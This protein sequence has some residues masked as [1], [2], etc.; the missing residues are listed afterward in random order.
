M[1]NENLLASIS[2]FAEL[3]NNKKDVRVV[4]NEFVKSVFSLERVF[5]ADSNKIK[6]LLVEH[7]GFDIPE[8]VIKSSLNSLKNQGMFSKH[9]G[10][11]Q[12]I[13]T[14]ENG[15][16]IRI[17]VDEKL[18]EQT[19]IE[20][21][22]LEYIIHEKKIEISDKDK[23][24]IFSCFTSYLLDT[25]ITDD[26]S[27]IISQ[28]VI[29][30]SSEIDFITALDNIREG[31]ILYQ[32]IV[33]SSDLNELD[34]WSKELVIYLDTELLFNS[35]GVNGEL[36][37]KLFD[38]FYEL[39]KDINLK[40]G[41]TKKLIH[42]KYF[43]EVEQEIQNYFYVAEKILLKEATLDPSKP[44]M[45]KILEGCSTISDILR[46]KADFF[47]NLKSR[48]ILEFSMEFNPIDN[49]QFNMIDPSLIEKYKEKNNEE[50]SEKKCIR[51]LEMFSKINTLRGGS[52]NTFFE[53]VGHIILTG[54]GMA[55]QISQDLD[56]KNN[57]KDIPFAT[58]IYF[59]TSRLWFKL[60]KGFNLSGKIPSI[61][62]VVAKAQVILSSQ[63]ND[64]V[65]K[66][67]NELKN[68]VKDGTMSTERAQSQYYA[69]RSRTFKPEDITESNVSE[70]VDFIFDDDFEKYLMEKSHLES[71]AK[72]LEE[73]EQEA[74]KLRVKATSSEI[75]AKEVMDENHK[76]K[77][78]KRIAQAQAKEA[79]RLA[80]SYE[81][82]KRK[83]RLS[84]FKR[85]T[86]FYY[87]GYWMSIIFVFITF[88]L[89][90]LNL[91]YLIK[92]PNDTLLD[93]SSLIIGVFFAVLPFISFTSLKKLA[94]RKTKTYYIKLLNASNKL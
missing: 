27:S 74:E 90:S 34:K 36:Y 49:P 1:K 41:T 13:G 48:G 5:S 79:M 70:V 94:L 64:K 73:V 12:Y 76:I 30:R 3:C 58:D 29:E 15:S 25:K 38:D 68:E 62:S 40:S 56:V 24:K 33:Y 43:S 63:L 11:Y 26:Y 20:K 87:R 7:F 84:R 86:K 69:L 65:S 18:K 85:K 45:I 21:E 60:N 53:N 16:D 2:L 17:G 23:D 72:R 10:Q 91:V 31:V 19:Q 88:L 39:V 42:L 66:K 59:V 77:E 78:E 54:K 6:N 37:Q 22:L 67:F 93:V 50:Q 75:L 80:K 9:E 51:I 35:Y 4:L 92:T 44:A 57:K 81:F 52:S 89:G 47:D 55:L 71:K 28:F 61:L 14:F 82:E 46:K 8:G 83:D 32:G